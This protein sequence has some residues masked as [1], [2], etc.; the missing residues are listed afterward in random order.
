MAKREQLVVGEL[1]VAGGD[2]KGTNI[3]QFREYSVSLTPAALATGPSVAEQTFTVTGVKV[4]DHIENVSAP[5]AQTAASAIIDARVSAADTVALT[6][7]ATAGTPTPVA[8]VYKIRVIR[9]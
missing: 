3:K 1:Q 8:G 2:D 4:G 5:S 7:L 6:F 9:T